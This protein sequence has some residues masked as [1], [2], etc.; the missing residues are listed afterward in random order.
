C[1]DV[2]FGL[3]E[4]VIVGV[5]VGES[6]RVLEDEV[7]VLE[8]IYE[9]G[10]RGGTHE[11]GRLAGGVVEAM[12]GVGG[13]GEEAAR[14]PLEDVL[15][16]A[17]LLPDFGGPVAIDYEVKLFVEVPLRLEGLPGRDLGHVMAGYA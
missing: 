5:P 11:Q 16:G 3:E 13:R 8:D 9:V 1:Q 10:R 4:V 15:A 6:E 2:V 12:P 7:V 17:A 14:L